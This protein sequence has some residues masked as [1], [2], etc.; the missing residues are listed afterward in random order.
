[1]PSL[2][3]ARVFSVVD[4]SNGFWQVALE[5]ESSLL[6]TFVTPFGRYRWRRLPFGI[7]SAPE[8]YQRRMNQELEGLDGIAIFADDVII[9]GCGQDDVAAEQ[10]HDIKLRKLLERCREKNLKLNRNKINFK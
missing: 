3:Q 2:H 7:S 8:E 1:M 6:T 4:A 9:F 5:E 10:D